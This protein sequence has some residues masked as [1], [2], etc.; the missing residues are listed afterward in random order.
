MHSLNILNNQIYAVSPTQPWVI[1]D[2][3]RM[4]IIMS[5]RVIDAMPLIQTNLLDS[6]D[7]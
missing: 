2:N 4:W 3:E 7:V 5:P 1:V 6:V